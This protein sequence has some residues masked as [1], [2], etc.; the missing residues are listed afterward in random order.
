MINNALTLR[1]NKS[2]LLLTLFV[3]LN[4]FFMCAIGEFSIA[5][6]TTLKQGKVFVMYAGSLVKIFEDVIGPA[7]Q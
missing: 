1:K 2:G 3:F 5:K 6:G 4:M 7:F